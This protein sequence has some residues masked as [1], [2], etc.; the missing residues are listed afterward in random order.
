MKQSIFLALL[1]GVMGFNA[2]A[3]ELNTDHLMFPEDVNEAVR[4][5]EARSTTENAT[6][7]NDEYAADEAWIGA[8]KKEPTNE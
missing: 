8:T 1:L 2:N 5:A 7:N 3:T 6:A 4:L